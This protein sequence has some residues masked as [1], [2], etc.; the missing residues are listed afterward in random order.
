MM[1][2]G[3]TQEKKFLSKISGKGDFVRFE[4]QNKQNPLNVY[5]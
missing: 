1:R 5:Q 4:L 3:S 2:Q